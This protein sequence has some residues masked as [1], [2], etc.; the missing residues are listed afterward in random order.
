MKYELKK[1]ETEFVEQ[2]DAQEKLAAQFS[3]EAEKIEA[4][5]RTAKDLK[6]HT[7]MKMKELYLKILRDETELQ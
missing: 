6:A 7:R 1:Q 2:I 5:L 4:K 3:T